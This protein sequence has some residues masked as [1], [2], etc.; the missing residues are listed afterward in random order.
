[1]N[2]KIKDR[3]EEIQFNEMGARGIASEI[4]DVIIKHNLSLNQADVIL[5]LAKDMLASKPLGSN[6]DKE[7]IEQPKDE[8]AP[9]RKRRKPDDFGV[10]CAVPEAEMSRRLT[11]AVKEYIRMH[12]LEGIDEEEEIN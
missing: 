7:V 6:V 4:C 11:L 12:G 3:L 1:M 5:D 8:K 9:K 10:I 2:K